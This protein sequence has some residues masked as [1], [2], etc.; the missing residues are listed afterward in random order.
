[1]TEVK[2]KPWTIRRTTWKGFPAELMTFIGT[3]EA[4]Y[5][6]FLDARFAD[7]REPIGFNRDS[8]APHS[9]LLDETGSKGIRLHPLQFRRYVETAGRTAPAWN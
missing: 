5:D 2:K 4:E 9:Y 3:T 1:M 7:A 8:S 6:E